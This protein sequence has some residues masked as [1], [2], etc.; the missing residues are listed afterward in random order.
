MTERLPEQA[1][2]F[3]AIVESTDDAVLSKT[4]D[5]TITSWNAAAERMYGYGRDEAVGNNVRMLLPPDRPGEIEGILARIREGEAV[6]HFDTQRRHKDGRIV[7]VSLTVSPVRGADGRVVGASTIARDVSERREAQ[8]ALERYT[9]EIEQSNRDL[10]R[11][12]YVVSHDLAEPL[13]MI[14]SFVQL[15]A[16]EFGD[17]LGDRGREYVD[18]ALEGSTR[19]RALIDD[20]LEYSRLGADDLAITAVDLGE[21]TRRVLQVLAN[22]IAETGAEVTVGDL[23]EVAGDAIKIEQVVRNLVAN[24][25]KFRRE[26]ERPRVAIRSERIPGAWQVS[27]VDEGIGIEL[28][29]A[30][31]VFEMFQRLHGRKDFPGTGVGLTICKRIVDRHGGRIW[32]EPNDPHGTRFHFTIPDRDRTP[33]RSVVVLLVEDNP[34]DVLLMRQGLATWNQ[35]TEVFVASD[36]EDALAFLRR[37]GRHADAPVP[38]LVVLDVNLPRLKGGE[39]LARMRTD[40]SLERIPV[41]VMSSS[42]NEGG[43]AAA[44]DARTTCFVLKPMDVAEYRAAVRG[45]ERFWTVATKEQ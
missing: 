6:E 34:G 20:L 21:V 44:Y 39:L 15:I 23:P 16:E 26:D 30:D 13:R 3:A 38:D 31:R 22:A 24:A 10:E 27:V 33:R 35:P 7:D 12:A 29:H 4:L 18:F 2:F 8:Q 17:D 36:G 42:S 1:A 28:R 11:F 14:S 41:A 43:I 32:F 40:P 9:R 5:G 37:E 45:V 25:L 19:M